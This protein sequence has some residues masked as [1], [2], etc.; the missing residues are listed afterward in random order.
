MN[1]ILTLNLIVPQKLRQIFNRV[2]SIYGTLVLAVNATQ[3]NAESHSS[4][5]VVSPIF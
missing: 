1:P 3:T 5:T 2:R 4:Q